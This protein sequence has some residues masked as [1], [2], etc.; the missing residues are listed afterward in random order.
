M[1]VERVNPSS[2]QLKQQVEAFFQQ[3]SMG[4]EVDLQIDNYLGV[5]S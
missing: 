2:E 5:F 4:K 3:K 1:L